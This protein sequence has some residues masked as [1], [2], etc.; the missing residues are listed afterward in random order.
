MVA[1][2]QG[3]VSDTATQA[4][5]NVVMFT[6]WPRMRLGKILLIRI[7]G[8][9][10]KAEAKV[11]MNRIAQPGAYLR[12]TGNGTPQAARAAICTTD[13]TTSNDLRLGRSTNQ[14]ATKV[15]ARFTNPN[16]SDRW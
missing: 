8:T 7:H 13:P 11:A 1:C 16:R 6:A 12:Q 5:M 3:K 4:N 14:M 2:S 15:N 9:G 10:P